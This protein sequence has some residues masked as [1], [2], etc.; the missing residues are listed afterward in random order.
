MNKLNKK[1]KGSVFLAYVDKDLNKVWNIYEGLTRRGVN[2]C[3]DNVGFEQGDWRA[4][5][6]KSINLSRCF[7][8]C[9]SDAALREISSRIPDTRDK[10]IRIAYEIAQNVIREDFVF[11]PVMIEDCCCGNYYLSS[12]L[13]NNLFSDFERKLDNLAVELGGR[14]LSDPDVI[15]RRNKEDKKINS[16]MGRAETAFYAG[17]YAKSIITWKH[18]LTIKDDI[19]KAWNNIGTALCKIDS[20]DDAIDAYD[21]AIKIRPDY[22][23]AWSNKAIALHKLGLHDAA[24]DAYKQATKF[25]PS[26]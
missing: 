21:T 9:I 8:V 20:N 23:E 2:V 14:S 7:V 3:F 26:N 1:N 11:V 16:L 10:N 19:Y 5:V 18:V 4:W 13:K 17:D 22:Y 15:D 6:S 24:T 12:L 25:K